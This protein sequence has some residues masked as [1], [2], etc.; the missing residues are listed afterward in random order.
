VD[1]QLQQLQ[2]QLQSEREAQLLE[3]QQEIA[4]ER[5][6]NAADVDQQLQLLQTQLQTERETQLLEMKE[7][8][9]AERQAM[10]AELDEQLRQL[11]FQLA[12]ERA[13]RESAFEA[14]LHDLQTQHAADSAHLELHASAELLDDI[15][16]HDDGDEVETE[17]GDEAAPVEG[18]APVC[19]RLT[20]SCCTFNHV[21]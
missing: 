16:A 21:G 9:A 4:A 7:K 2:A 11:E 15:H 5:A 3:M 8:I 18:G 10:A 6:K 1:R 14:Q 12:E 13:A 20:C 19:W 17:D